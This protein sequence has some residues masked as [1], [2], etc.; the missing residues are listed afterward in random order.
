MANAPAFG[1]YSHIQK[2]R[3]LSVI[4][5]LGLFALVYMLLFAALLV[6][7]TQTQP[8][9]SLN[10]YFSLA[11]K[12]SLGYLPWVLGAVLLWIIIA[13]FANS[14]MIS[15]LSGSKSIERHENQQLYDQL[16]VLCISVGMQMPQLKII[17]TPALNAFASGLTPAQHT[18]TV[19]QGL[20]DALNA[21]EIEAVLAH[22]L[23][24]IR[25]E[26]VKLMVVATLI[27]GVISLFGELIFR[28][29]MNTNR[30]MHWGSES[31]TSRTSSGSSS[32]RDKS[33][34]GAM[35]AFIIAIV[36]IVIAWL[37][38][39]MIRLM[40]SRTREFLADAGAVELTKNPDA[41]IAALQ[42]ISGKGKIEG[43]PSAIMEMCLDN[44][45]SGLSNLFSTHPTIEKRIEALIQQAGGRI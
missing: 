38:S 10:A 25:N 18:I 6:F 19:T 8:Y 34:G 21:N 33:G 30:A 43:A 27:A 37:L 14:A 1:L 39:Q 3:R 17:D 44:P 20:L 42:K 2:N 23:T 28:F 15:S 32:Q 4:L 5:V 13:Y 29:F 40:L 26:D 45:A 22:E 11:T 9:L 31:Q 7:L 12:Q 41:M 24:H 35:A 16:E 36:F